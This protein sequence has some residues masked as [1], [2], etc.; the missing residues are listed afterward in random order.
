MKLVNTKETI[1]V[2]YEIVNGAPDN[3][4]FS[5]RKMSY[6]EVSQILDETSVI[7]DQNEIVYKAGT[8]AGLK[9]KYSLVSWK[10]VTDANDKEIPCTPENKD[11]LPVEIITWL[12]KKID[13]LNMLEGVSETQRKNS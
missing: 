5:L 2:T 7:N 1:D 13:T 12:A 3:P 9:V 8:V 6:A 4:K 11:K 10:N